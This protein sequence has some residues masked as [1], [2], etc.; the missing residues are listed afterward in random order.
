MAHHRVGR[1]CLDR[2]RSR[3][4]HRE[5]PLDDHVP[6]A[7]TSPSDEGDPEE[8]ALMAESVGLALLVVLDTLAP[9][10]RLAFVLH[11]MFAVPFDEIASILGRSPNATKQLAS[12]A[13][14]WVQR[15]HKCHAEVDSARQVGADKR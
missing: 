10:E 11:D 9:A 14:P 3:A 1:V 15:D 13:R 8:E 12:R 5:Q 7:P 4:A 6:Q 2:R